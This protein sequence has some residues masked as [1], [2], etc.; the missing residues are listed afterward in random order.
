MT[1]GKYSFGIGDRFA[2]EGANLLK[3]LIRVEERF[4]VHFTPVWDK[5][6]REHVIIGTVPAETR[7][8]ADAAVRA[9]GYSGAYFCDADHINFSNVDRFIDA[10]DFFTIDVVDCIGA[11]GTPEARYL[12]ASREIEA[13][14]GDR[15]V[16][17]LFA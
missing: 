6:T 16:K 2:H 13:N 15:H 7:Q 14:I 10:C 1:I 9:C 3:A 5:S 4:G 11:S 8:A 17:L 12:P